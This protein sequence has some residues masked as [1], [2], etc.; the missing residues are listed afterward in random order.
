MLIKNLKK[1]SLHFLGN[2]LL[3][4]VIRVLCKT[5]K[6][7]FV[8]KSAIEKLE[9]SNQ[10]YVL[11][12]WHGTML[13]AWY[14]NRNKNMSAIVSQ[15]KDGEILTR[16][17]KKWKYEIAR[18]SSHKGGKEAM[19]ILLDFAQNKKSVSI[20][21]DGPTGPINVMKPGAVITAKKCSIPLVLAG[22]GYNN[23]YEFKS[24]DKFKLPKFFSVSKIIYSDPIYIDSSLDYEATDKIIKECEIKLNKLQEEA[25]KFA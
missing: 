6:Y 2:N 21:P 10:N 18:G 4:I 22:V 13:T 19:N 1:K 15:S 24:W 17:L 3:G 11:A 9:N 14:L 23:Y 12:F 25:Q 16:L 20:T 7:Q 8:N 5:V